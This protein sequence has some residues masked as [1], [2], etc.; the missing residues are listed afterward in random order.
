V[1]CPT[2]AIDVEEADGMRKIPQW[3]RTLPMARCRECGRP[4]A[5]AFQLESFARQIKVDPARFAL[6]PD[7]R[8]GAMARRRPGAKAAAPAPAPSR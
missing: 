3:H 7:C 6:C 4:F 5:P 1:V 8:D 2:G